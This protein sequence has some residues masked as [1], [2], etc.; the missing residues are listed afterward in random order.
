MVTFLLARVGYGGNHARVGDP[1]NL[2]ENWL[3]WITISAWMVISPTLLLGILID[4]PIGW[5][6]AINQMLNKKDIL[7][8]SIA[9]IFTQHHWRL[10]LHRIRLLN[11]RLQQFTS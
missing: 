6:L 4:Q 5:Q 8:E 1:A 3:S 9:G 11:H 2:N 7:F 10:S